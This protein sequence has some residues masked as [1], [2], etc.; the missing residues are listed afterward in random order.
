MRRFAHVTV[1]QYLWYG[2]VKIGSNCKF[3]SQLLP[4]NIQNLSRNYHMKF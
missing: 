2:I 4:K 1:S 3:S